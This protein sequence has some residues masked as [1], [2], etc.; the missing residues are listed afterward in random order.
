MNIMLV[1]VTER[2]REIGIR[3]S[4]GARRQD[5]LVQFLIEAVT[6]SILGAA[7]GVG[8]GYGIGALVANLLPGDWPPAHVTAGLEMRRAI[9]RVVHGDTV[10]GDLVQGDAGGWLAGMCGGHGGSEDN[11]RGG[12]DQHG[13]WY[14]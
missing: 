14:G 9:D 4:V 7:I 12:R 1:S 8:V 6:L 3:K 13:R 10:C 11:G 5:I 2:T